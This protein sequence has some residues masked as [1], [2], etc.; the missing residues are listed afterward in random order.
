MALRSFAAGRCRPHSMSAGAMRALVLAAA[1]LPAML[2]CRETLSPSSRVATIVITG[3]ATVRAAWH[4]PFHAR[5][6]DAQGDSVPG[7]TPSWASSDTAVAIVNANGEVFSRGLGQTVVS[8]QA[9]HATG[10][11]TVTVTPWPVVSVVT[12][13]SGDSV[14]VGDSLLLHAWPQDSLGRGLS[15][16]AVTWTSSDTAKA[17]VSA[18]GWVRVKAPGMVAIR[19]QSESA[20]GGAFVL[21]Q[22]RAARLRLPDTL[23]L[24]ILNAVQVLPDIED[25]AGDLLSDRGVTWQSTDTTVVSVTADGVLSPRKTGTSDLIARCCGG[26]SDTAVVLV[27]DPAIGFTVLT[28]VDHLRV[29]QA[30]TFKVA[31]Y[32]GGYGAPDAPIHWASEDTTIM[33]VVPQADPH[34]ATLTGRRV[35]STYLDVAAD[36]FKMRV[37]IPTLAA[38]GG[39][40]IQPET[41]L[42]SVGGLAPLHA[43]ILDAGGNV[44]VPDWGYYTELVRDT[45]I[46]RLAASSNAVRGVSVG[47]TRVVATADYDGQMFADSAVVMVRASS[48]PVLHWSAGTGLG[49]PEYAAVNTQV[50]VDSSG[51]PVAY[52]GDIALSASD[53]SVSVSPAV[54]HGINGPTTVTIVSRSGRSAFVNARADSMLGTL[55]LQVSD[56]TYFHVM[57]LSIPDTISAGDSVQAT[58]T[59]WGGGLFWHYPMAWTSSDTTVAALGPGQWLHARGPGTAVITARTDTVVRTAVVAVPAPG[60][61]IGATPTLVYGQPAVIQGSGFAASPAGDTVLVDGV[62]AAVTAASPTQLTIVPG[63]TPASCVRA[64]ASLLTV[65]TGG[66]VAAKGVLLASATQVQL[67]VNGETRISGAALGCTELVLGTTTLGGTYDLTVTDSSRSPTETTPLRL[68]GAGMGLPNLQPSA[69]EVAVAPV[70]ALRDS[71]RQAVLRHVGV[72]E[73]GLAFEAAAGNPVPQLVARPRPMRAV[74]DS[75]GAMVR[76]KIPRADRPDFCSSYTSVTAER[77]FTGPH[78]SVFLDSVIAMNRDDSTAAAALGADFETDAWPTVTTYFGNPLALDTLLGG[79][80][81]VTVLMSPVVDDYA[82]AFVAACDFYPETMAP[83]SNVGEVIYL[84][85]QTAPAGFPGGVAGYWQWGYR[86]VLVHELKHIASFAERLS[87]GE[88]PEADWLEEGSAVIA[89]ELW[90]RNVYRTGWKSG[91]GYQW[92]IYCDVRPV[93]CPGAPYA[94]FNAFALLYDFANGRATPPGTEAHTPLGPTSPADGSFYGSAWS[95][96]RWSID[97]YATSEAD[98]LHAM[99]TDG[100]HTGTANLEARTGRPWQQ[101]LDDWILATTLAGQRA[102]RLTLTFPSWDLPYIFA[103]MAADFPSDFST[104]YPYTERGFSGS[105]LDVPVTLHGGSVAMVRVQGVDETALIQVTGQDGSPAPAGVVLHIIRLN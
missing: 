9:G 17:V 11:T 28:S 78:V 86:T 87:R 97:Q 39:Y 14:Y 40:A 55:W 59:G 8:A 76:F 88:G 5:L 54:L 96:I 27:V 10:A 82:T 93:A 102:P 91:A 61:T 41:V 89:E 68:Y 83:S 43:D 38:V 79:G 33:T 69:P 85:A 98:F 21:G 74:R 65:K 20:V 1:L 58:A 75:V 71:I 95:L 104:S 57:A 13:A 12:I 46:A 92:T 45:T 7:V 35:G 103:G 66:G 64:H 60:P 63:G 100:L 36:S 26:L 77:V 105:V 19:A 56:S 80:G 81:R 51:A 32:H 49:V 16:R 73:R 22:A 52:A 84:S 30:A 15:G 70:A 6:L 50:E 44:L 48:R 101:L 4:V 72:L 31:E 37:L 23:S 29:G 34:S 94:M 2:T 18:A 24:R 67:D 25:S 47:T 3:P 99:L 62:P 90:S 53:P 42:V